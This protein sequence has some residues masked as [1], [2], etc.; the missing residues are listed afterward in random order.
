MTPEQQKLEELERRLKAIERVENIPFMKSL[1]RRMTFIE[2]GTEGD[3]TSIT[4]NVRN[5][6][7]TGTVDVAKVP[8]GKLEIELTDGTIRYIAVYNS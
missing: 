5:S 3:A 6:A 7:G 8:D 4:Q 1:I 2:S